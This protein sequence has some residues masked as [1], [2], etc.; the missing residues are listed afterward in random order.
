MRSMR[1][2]CKAANCD[3]RSMNGRC[4]LDGIHNW[5]DKDISEFVRK[6]MAEGR[7]RGKNGD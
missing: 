3:K 5:S 6:V 7:K 2:N 1:D 4:L